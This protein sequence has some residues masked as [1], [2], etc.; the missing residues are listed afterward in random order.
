MT[1][2]A[3]SEPGQ[4]TWLYE[5]REVPLTD[6]T[7]LSRLRP[8]EPTLVEA[9]AASMKVA[10]LAHAIVL[11]PASAGYYLVVGWHRLEAARK[12]G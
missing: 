5:T 1:E 4:S 12:L 3:R 6:I 10:G 11:R 2:S 8:L 9:L 7:V